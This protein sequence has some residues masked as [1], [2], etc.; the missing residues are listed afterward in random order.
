[1]LDSHSQGLIRTLS[2]HVYSNDVYHHT[3]PEESIF[4][5]VQENPR[6]NYSVDCAFRSSFSKSE[7]PTASFS[8]TSDGGF[9]PKMSTDVKR[10]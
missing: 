3:L 5:H 1:M 8:A 4:I 6:N 9:C 10:S 2:G 7:R